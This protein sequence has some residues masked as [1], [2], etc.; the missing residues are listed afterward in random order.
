MKQTVLSG[1]LGACALSLAL[2]S[3]VVQAAFTTGSALIPDPGGTTYNTLIDGD[4]NLEWLSL[5]ATLGVSVYE[6]YGYPTGG[7]GLN[8]ALFGNEFLG[9]DGNATTPVTIDSGDYTG[10]RLATA[11]EV[12]EM[13]ISAGATIDSTTAGNYTAANTIYDVL[14]WTADSSAPDKQ[15]DGLAW[16][17]NASTD[18]GQTYN[19]IIAACVNTYTLSETG[20]FQI[21]DP[22]GFV[23]DS[24]NPFVGLHLVREAAVVPVPAAVT[25]FGCSPPA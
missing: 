17:S 9:G 14:G 11:A 23:A 7:S 2:V 22:A 5:E 10:W 21:H 15:S 3:G 19:E 6:A 12:E 18:L 25:S 1:A 4:T 8:P 16:D 13:V 24:V 20:L